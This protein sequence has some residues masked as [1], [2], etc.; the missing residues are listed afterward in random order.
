LEYWNNG[1]MGIGKMGDWFILL[2][3]V[4]YGKFNPA[5]VGIFD[6]PIFHVR[7][8][9]SKPQKTPWTSVPPM[10]GYKFRDV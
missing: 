7:G 8:I 1:I 10:A 9:N 4:P 3:T 5:E 6:I 2:N